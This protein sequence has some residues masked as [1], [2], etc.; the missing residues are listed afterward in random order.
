[1]AENPDVAAHFKE[2]DES[3]VSLGHKIAQEIKNAEELLKSGIE[4]AHSEE[5]REEFQALLAAIEQVEKEYAEYEHL[6]E[7][8]LAT[9]RD[10]GTLAHDSLIE[11]FEAEE[12]SIHHAV[13]ASQQK[14]EDFTE[15][16]IVAAENLDHAVDY[17]AAAK[18]DR[19]NGPTCQWRNVGR[20]DRSKSW[21]R[22]QENRGCGKGL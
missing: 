8:V 10:G 15:R 5:A 19:H 22:D 6:S 17:P 12:K 13:S 11:K 20:S 7:G 21:R 1:M 16:S 14:I 3:F 9:I 2:I 18:Y 4:Q